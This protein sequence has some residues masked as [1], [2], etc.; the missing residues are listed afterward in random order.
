MNQT[1]NSARL[2]ADLMFANVLTSIFTNYTIISENLG[3]DKGKL[4][5]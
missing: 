2:I 5:F 3:F 4:F 1:F